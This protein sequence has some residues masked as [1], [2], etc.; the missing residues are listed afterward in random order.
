MIVWE[1]LAAATVGILV[2]WFVLAPLVGDRSPA[3]SAEPWE[4]DDPEETPRGI[5]LAALKDIEFDRAT[6]KLAEADYADLKARY[7]A[8]AVAAMRAEDAEQ[9]ADDIEAMIAA[10]ARALRQERPAACAV[11]GPRP[12]PDAVFCSHCGRPLPLP[13]S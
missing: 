1:A 6:D 2:L 4:P 8:A 7:S 3:A 10:R 11:C 5:A 13:T 12:E 9:R